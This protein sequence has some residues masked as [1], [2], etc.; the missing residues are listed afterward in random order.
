LKNLFT[1]LILLIAFSFSVTLLGNESVKEYFPTTL[2]S[3][4]VYVDEDK[5]ELTRHAVEEEEI[6]GETYHAFSYEPELEELFY[7]SRYMHPTLYQVNEKGITFV[8]QDQIDKALKAQLKKETEVLIDAFEKLTTSEGGAD[9]Q[10]AFDIEVEKQDQLY[11]FPEGITVNEEWD[12]IQIGAKIKMRPTGTTASGPEEIIFDFTINETGNVLGTEAVETPAGKFEGCLK[13]EYRTE[14]T[15]VVDPA[16]EG[17]DVDLPG[18]T[19]TTLWF[20]PN[21][22]IVK[23]NQEL[24]PIFLEII[25]DDAGLPIPREPQI[26][27]LELKKYEIKSEGE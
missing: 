10:L 25:P 23:L 9:F 11:L 12:V 21:V 20:A 17:G 3:Y 16:D 4:W 14:T 1:I 2:G 8:F 13:I 5:N 15:L 18:E 22:G 26:R 19:V 27:T 6:A 24:Q 7:F